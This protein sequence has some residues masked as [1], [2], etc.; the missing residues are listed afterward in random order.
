[1]FDNHWIE[2]FAGVYDY[3]AAAGKPK[4]RIDNFKDS[5]NSQ[6]DNT[7]EPNHGYS[8]YDDYDD[9]QDND[10]YPVLQKRSIDTRYS[11]AAQRER[12]ELY[13]TVEGLMNK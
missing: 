7:A 9:S 4:Q 10:N 3:A 6:D 12:V 11:W 13:K 5:Y 2:K 1:M 8:N